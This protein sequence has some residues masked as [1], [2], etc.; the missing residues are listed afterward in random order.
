LQL[1]SKMRYISSQFSAYLSNEQWKKTATHANGMAKL[2][3]EELK[4]VPQVEITQNVD[5]NGVFAIIPSE[6]IPKL[7]NEY[8]FYVWDEHQSEVR[9]MTS[10]DTTEEDIKGFVSTLKSML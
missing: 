3:A 2:L 7:Q 8:F 9:W 1:A 6:I 10:W 4:N 5:V